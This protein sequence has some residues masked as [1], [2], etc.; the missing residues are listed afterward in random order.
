MAQGWCP[1]CETLREITPTGEEIPK[2]RGQR[3]W[4]LVVHPKDGK[5]CE[6]SGKK[7]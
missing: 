3:Y 1:D 6:G 5:I 4:Q 2:R 7:I